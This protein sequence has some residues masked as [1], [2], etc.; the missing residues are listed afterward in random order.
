LNPAASCW[1]TLLPSL[2][3]APPPP[4]ASFPSEATRGRAR[5]GRILHPAGHLLLHSRR[6]PSSPFPRRAGGNCPRKVRK[7]IRKLLEGSSFLTTV[8]FSLSLKTGVFIWGFSFMLAGVSQH[9]AKRPIGRAGR[10]LSERDRRHWDAGA[11]RWGGLV[12]NEFFGVVAEA[13]PPITHSL[14]SLSCIAL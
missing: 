3:S 14:W 12:T 2:G 11:W 5:G 6:L 10:C 4:A 1:L 8:L 13:A 9:L 7:G